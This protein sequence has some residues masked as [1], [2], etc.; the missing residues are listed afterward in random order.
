MSQIE[1]EYKNALDDVRFS[2]AEKER[3]MNNLMNQKE[4]EQAQVGRRG[5]RPLRA[6]L[7]GHHCGAAGQHQ[8][9]R[10]LWRSGGRPEGAAG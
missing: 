5:F 9:P 3:M 4:Q 6:G 8:L 2:E 10:Q 1:R 7:I